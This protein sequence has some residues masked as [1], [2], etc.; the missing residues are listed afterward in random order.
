MSDFQLQTATERGRTVVS[1]AGECD[2]RSRDELTS[3]LHTAVES[4]PLVIVDLSAVRFLDSS[5]LHALVSA[6]QAARR[7][8]GNLHVVNAR[9]TVATVL[10]ITGV[11]DLLRPPGEADGSRAHTPEGSW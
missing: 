10:E 6:H 3:A 1:V 9:G 11:I 7:Q 5:G 8:A 2:L 4:A